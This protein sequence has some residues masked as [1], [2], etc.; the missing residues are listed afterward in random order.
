[1]VFTGLGSRLRS[2]VR[3]LRVLFVSHTSDFSGAEVALLR[4][5]GGLPSDVRGAVACPPH[6]P[7]ADAL[8]AHGVE[9]LK[10]PGT[11][12]SFRLSPV[13]SARGALDLARSVQAVRRLARSWRADVIHANGVRAGLLAVAARRLGAPAV[14]VQVHDQ[15]P[16][17][18]MGRAVRRVL[19]RADD[20]IAVSR[21]TGRSFD[22]DL[23]RPVATTVYISI[24]AARFALA[25]DDG[26]VR[27]ALGIPLEAPLLGEVAQ[28]T[29]WKGQLEAIETL[30][31][32]RREMPEARLLLVG[33]VAF[34]GPG[35]RYDNRAYLARLHDRVRELGLQDA[36]HF[37][38][39]RDDVPAL[40]SALD[41]LLL[42]SVG[43][44]FGT[45]A[46]EGMA[47]GTVAFVGEDGG[48]AEYIEDGV[49]GRALPP[50][51]PEQWAV[52]ALGLLRAPE[53]RRAM[54][55]R[56]RAVAA[57]FTD[58]AYATA[59]LDAYAR[60]RFGRGKAL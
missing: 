56:A 34:S 6:G 52:A 54:G 44:P 26:S 4:L 1:M 32:V 9:R 48:A 53:Q 37:L 55:E 13:T 38:G 29:P 18:A 2:T 23:P 47:A 30:A 12:L 49:T 45:A 51:D 7:L 50:R 10:I 46:L 35:V 22:A 57:R 41:L 16:H 17:S 33:H 15:L 27:A 24:D 25:R 3:I 19:A 20:V 43:E 8:D 42:P 58:E 36:V 5:L 28:I 11:T 39:R 60:A 21:S 14:V 31:L 59:C 40:L